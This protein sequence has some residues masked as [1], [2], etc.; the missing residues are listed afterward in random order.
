[1][2]KDR[3]RALCNFRE[4]G[5]EFG[6]S[7]QLTQAAKSMGR[8]FPTEPYCKRLQQVTRNKNVEKNHKGDVR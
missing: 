2:L 8:L 5:N 6:N 4:K 1:M 3:E 7:K